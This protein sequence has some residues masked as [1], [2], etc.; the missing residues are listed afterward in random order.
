MWKAICISVLINLFLFYAVIKKNSE[1]GRFEK[2]LDASLEFQRSKYESKMSDIDKQRK[3]AIT[4]LEKLRREN[5]KIIADL[6]HVDKKRKD[7]ER[8][9]QLLRNNVP[10]EI[11]FAKDG[12]PVYWNPNPHKPYGD[13]TVYVNKKTGIFHIDYFCASYDSTQTHLFKAIN[14]ARP[15]QKCARNYSDLTTIPD[16]FTKQEESK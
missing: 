7:V 16:W 13:Y 1:I 3:E 14:C 12:M 11:S 9:L 6:E 8:E 15:C 4:E 5:R 10:P 2:R